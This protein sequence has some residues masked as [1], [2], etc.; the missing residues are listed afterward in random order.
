MDSLDAGLTCKKCRGIRVEKQHSE[1]PRKP[2]EV[3]LGGA[4]SRRTSLL[5]ISWVEKQRTL[6]A[7]YSL[8][9]QKSLRLDEISRP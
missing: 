6:L 2:T 4:S 9:N 1:G 3:C 5:G 8:E 7:P